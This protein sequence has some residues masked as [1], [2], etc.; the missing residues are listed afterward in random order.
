VS[1]VFSKAWSQPLVNL[2]SINLVLIKLMVSKSLGDSESIAVAKKLGDR[3]C[4]KF[5][6]KQLTISQ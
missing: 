4:P 1:T 3:S 6:P 5:K 2:E